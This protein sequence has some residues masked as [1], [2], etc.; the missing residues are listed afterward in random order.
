[1]SP[2]STMLLLFIFTVLIGCQSLRPPH[3][4]PPKTEHSETKSVPENGL[5]PIDTQLG[6]KPLGVLADEEDRSFRIQ[7]Y[8]ENSTP[9]NSAR[10]ALSTEL[11]SFQ[12]EIAYQGAFLP[13]TERIEKDHPA[14]KDFQSQVRILEYQLHPS[15][16]K[17]ATKLK[18]DLYLYLYQKEFRP[19]NSTFKREFYTTY[20]VFES[21]D[22]IHFHYTGSSPHSTPGNEN[23]NTSYY[24]SGWLPEAT[25]CKYYSDTYYT[26]K[27]DSV[28]A[29]NGRVILDPL[30]Q[31]IFVQMQFAFHD[32]LEHGLQAPC[33]QALATTNQI[34]EGTGV[35]SYR[36]SMKYVDT[37]SRQMIPFEKL[38]IQ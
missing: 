12:A 30:Q 4:A 33:S 19:L 21:K 25:D 32:K 5:Y 6:Q 1:M 10:S 15:G 35:V 20:A 27:N 38:Y 9:E 11:K 37:F 28:T 16:Q 22:G 24:Y 14:L 3:T 8:P 31:E 7:D 23:G 2:H 29:R 13:E 26:G 36:A 18:L 17:I 34:V